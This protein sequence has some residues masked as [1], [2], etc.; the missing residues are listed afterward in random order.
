MKA[1]STMTDAA[2]SD[3]RSR[4][5]HTVLLATESKNSALS[6]VLGGK[7]NPIAYSVYGEQSAPQE[8]TTRL[9][10]NG[11]L[12]EARPGWY[13]LGNGY[14]AYNP[15]LMRFHSPDSWS[16]FGE[17]GLNAYMYCGGEPVM[18]SD[19]TG[20]FNPSKWLGNITSFLTGRHRPALKPSIRS[21]STE[22]LIAKH[23][24]TETLTKTSSTLDLTIVPDT[25]P[26]VDRNLKPPPSIDRTTKPAPTVNRA[27]KPKK[28]QKRPLFPLP[29]DLEKALSVGPDKEVRVD[30]DI[31]S[32][33]LRGSS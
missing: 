10:F 19:P 30:L 1:G 3:R 26:P 16:P 2:N 32:A 7:P 21:S 27:L 4:Q 25:A 31:A 8:I 17:G 23:E 24:S 14:R 13:L 11:Q 18:G 20:H 22:K 33:I 6:E 5:S 15:V 29:F 12:R 28:P 9:G